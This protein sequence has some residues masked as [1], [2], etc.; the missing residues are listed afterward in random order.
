MTRILGDLPFVLIFID[1][2]VIFSKSREEHAEQVKCVIE[3]LTKAK[4][5][6]NREKSHFFATQIVL[7]GFVI[8]LKGRRVDPTKLA[9]IDQWIAPTTSTQIQSYMGTFNFFREYIPLFSTLAAPLDKL[10]NETRT[11]KLTKE[12]LDS[13]NAFKRLLANAPILHFADFRELFYIATDASNV[14]IAA[15]L[16]QRIYNEKT[17]KVET[18]YISFMARS[19][20]DRERRYSATQKELLGIVFALTKYHYYVW[21]RQFTHYTDHRALTF[22]HTQKELNSMLTGWH[23]TILSYNFKIEYR[24][25][26]MN[27]LPDHLSRLFPATMRTKHEHKDNHIFNAYMHVLQSKD[28]PLKVIDNKQQ[29]DDILQKTHSFGHLGSNAMV[30]SIH[31]EQVTWPHLADDCLNWIKKCVECQ[32]YNIAQKG[33]HPLRAIHAELPGDHMAVDTA[34]PFPATADGNTRLLIL[35]DVCT[36][37]VFLKP[38]RDK[39]A[40]T[41]GRAFFDIFCLI[42][43]PRILQS[44]NGTE[45]VNSLVSTMTTQLGTKHRLLTPYHPRG[46]F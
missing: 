23:E 15:V 5:I 32:K 4:L 22:I 1:D 17:K 37:F 29:Q 46:I 8:D 40:I 39:M 45:F 33:Y 21:G 24:P 18:R 31:A 28:V 19:L 2:I 38:I 44:D 41:V 3:R 30:R 25:G 6:I 27:V 35:V 36:R 13:F 26:V 42:G 43:F 12:E 34:G 9:N 11:F 7:L 20:Q 14:G 10:R 16:Y